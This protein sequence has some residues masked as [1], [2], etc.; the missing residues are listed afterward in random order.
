MNK[1]PAIFCATKTDTQLSKDHEH[2]TV[3]FIVDG[4]IKQGGKNI[5]AAERGTGKTRI[6]LFIA[7]AIIYE[8]PQI[9]GYKISQFGDVLF[10]NLEISERDFKAFI[11]PI[12]RYF[13]NTLKLERKYKLQ[14]SS[15]RE[16]DIKLNDIK[17]IVQE[18]KP[19][20]TIID[21][22]KIYQSLVCKEE[23][24]KEITNSNFDK[25]LKLMDE[26]V[27]QF[28]TTIVL[29]NHT[30]KGTSMMR[31]NSDLMF[32][33]GALPDFVDHVTLIRKTKNNNQRIIVPDK[34]RYCGEG[35]ITT[36]LIEI[37][38]SDLAS[39]NPNELYFELIEEDVDEAEH[40]AP[41]KGYRLPTETKQKIIELADEGL[42]QAKIAELALGNKALKGTISKILQKANT[43]SE[44]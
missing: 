32:G 25:V 15:F 33:P 37:K 1:L 24:Q 23:G 14:I 36:N 18:Y 42:T 3:K 29:I 11:E 38:S 7:Y 9:F 28:D 40:L 39:A 26:L 8:C 13:E 17:L 20:L 6:L 35:Q 44:E 16:H 27:S 41:R 30:N 34:S 10:I 22:Y 21:S 2:Y 4:L 31:S 19:L 43:N 12:R 5:F